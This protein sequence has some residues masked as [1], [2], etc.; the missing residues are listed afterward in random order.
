MSD[1]FTLHSE[2]DLPPHLFVLCTKSERKLYDTKL[3]EYI[4]S[5]IKYLSYEILYLEFFEKMKKGIIDIRKQG[6]SGINKNKDIN[7]KTDISV[8]FKTKIDETSS[9]IDNMNVLKNEAVRKEAEVE[10]LWFLL[11][12]KYKKYVIEIMNNPDKLISTIE[13]NE[14]LNQNNMNTLKKLI[15][16]CDDS[17][18][19]YLKSLS[20]SMLNHKQNNFDLKQKH[21]RDSSSNIKFFRDFNF[22]DKCG[23]RK[24]TK[25]A[26]VDYINKTKKIN[27]ILL[28][29]P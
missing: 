7:K 1:W 28:Q 4:Q 27:K 13:S 3:R 12:F 14:K 5:Y 18:K 11:N 23:A 22:E 21:T 26:Y 19:K 17:Y 2:Y 15:Y 16:S 6:N 29:Q 24:L 25:K 9:L 10:F 8:L 20:G